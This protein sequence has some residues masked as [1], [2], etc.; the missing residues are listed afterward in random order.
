LKGRAFHK[1]QA[2]NYI[3]NLKG[4]MQ[5][6]IKFIVVLFFCFSAKVFS[7]T[8]TSS[9]QFEKMNLKSKTVT[10]Y[11]YFIKSLKVPEKK[12]VQYPTKH[13]LMIPVNWYSQQFGFFCRQELSFEKATRLP[14]RF[15]LGSLDYC[16][17]MEGK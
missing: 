10:T 13:V 16:N 4:W 7:Q 15:R 2:V 17:R 9:L 1:N 6:Q 11:S 14:V 5:R 12:E 8:E 3:Q